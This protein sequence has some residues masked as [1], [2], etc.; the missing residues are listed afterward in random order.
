MTPISI[1]DLVRVTEGTDA[2][3]ALDNARDLARPRRDLG[4]SAVLGRRAS[5]HG[6][7]RQRRDRGGDRPYR[8]RH[9]DHPGRRGRDHAAQPRA[10]DHR[11][12]VRHPGAA[13]PGRIDLGLGRAPG[14]D[15]ITAR[16]LRRTPARRRK[17][18]P[19]DVVELQASSAPRAGP[20]SPAVP[21]AG[22][23]VPLW[24]L[25]SSLYGAHLAA[26]LGLPY[27]FASHFAPDA[28]MPALQIYRAGSS[29]PSSCR[30]PTRW[31]A[32]TSSR[33]R[34]TPKRG[35]WPPP[36]RVSFVNRLAR[37]GGSE[38]AADRRY[39]GLLVADGKGAGDAA[40]LAL[41]RGIG[42]YGAIGDSGAGRGNRGRRTDDRVGRLRS[43][44]AA[45]V[46]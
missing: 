8:R 2:R 13:V 26:E 18:F 44:G 4:L 5:Q 30:G 35:G 38:P 25:G 45:G 6:R 40:A 24:I 12:A 33:P 36:S 37:A 21:A 7:R 29:R 22:T 32:S 3:G 11:R 14:T 17:N 27:A 16:A 31:S 15:Q 23:E 9:A 19:R 41:D 1:L 10:A 34:P 46:L 28:L 20:E 39:R 43:R 42:R